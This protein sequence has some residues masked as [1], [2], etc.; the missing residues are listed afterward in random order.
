MLHHQNIEFKMKKTTIKCFLGSLM[1]VFA[2]Q[3]NAQDV[4]QMTI[5]SSPA[6][7]ILSFE[8]T[9][10]MKPSSSKDFCANVLNSFDKDG[11]LK[12]NLGLEVTP[13]WLKSRPGLTRKDYLNPSLKQRFLQ[14]L[15]LSA[16]TFKDTV[17]KKDKLGLGVRFKLFNGEP[18][19]E[20]EKKEKEL[21]K[22]GGDISNAINS[23]IGLVGITINSRE[24]AINH[25][26]NT[27]KELGYSNATI[28]YFAE[29][30][31]EL[32]DKYND[33]AEGV[34]SFIKEMNGN[35][36]ESNS[37]LI[38]QVS[39]LSKKRV[40]FILEVACATSLITA[41]NEETLERAGVWVN[42][43]NYYTESDCWTISGRYMLANRDSS[44]T[45][46]D[47]GLSYLKELIN[48]NISVEGML[49]WYRAEMPDININNE[50][51]TK[52]EKDFTYRIAVQASYKLTDVIS[53]NLSLGKDFSSPF[54]TNSSFFTIFGFSYNFF[55]PE[56]V[57]LKQ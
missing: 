7:S 19:K 45:N 57:N 8:P 39:L 29:G 41:G 11:K 13:Y 2:F 9:A 49:R 37:K 24:S 32:A 52:V 25:I 33:S 36:I 4:T 40:G 23:A 38:E 35:L 17:L 6:F 21:Q 34:K 50:P 18:T 16:A 22:T 3:L 14:S 54:I 12:M 55:K 20:Y 48:F 15:S 27:L 44:I 10:V 47:L 51:I 28:K 1:M 53:F 43:S 56:L 5:P 31:K 26:T 46:G 30:A 42:A